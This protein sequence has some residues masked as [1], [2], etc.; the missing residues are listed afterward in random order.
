V[1]GKRLGHRRRDK[2]RGISPDPA[3]ARSAETLQQPAD[4][5]NNAL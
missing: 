5:H 2:P 1:T 4:L 3:A